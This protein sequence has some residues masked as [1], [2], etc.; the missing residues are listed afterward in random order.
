MNFNDGVRRYHFNGNF[1]SIRILVQIFIFCQLPA[2]NGGRLPK[3]EKNE[4][5]LWYRFSPVGGIISII[6]M[7][8]KKKERKKERTY[9]KP[10]SL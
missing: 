8:L 5:F 2:I 4:G 6:S 9:F 1:D 10:N 3:K 7:V